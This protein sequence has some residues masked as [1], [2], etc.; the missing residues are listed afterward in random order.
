MRAAWGFKLFCRR[1][2]ANELSLCDCLA[3]GANRVRALRPHC[4]I[5]EWCG[6]TD[7]RIC[8]IT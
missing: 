1:S 8:P 3:L 7:R 5:D 4:L 6:S 2:L